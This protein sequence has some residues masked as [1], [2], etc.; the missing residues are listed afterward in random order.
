MSYASLGKAMLDQGMSYDGGSY[1]VS[2][3]RRL[4]QAMSGLVK[5]CYAIQRYARWML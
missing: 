2:M 5:L 3:G 4:G 1:A